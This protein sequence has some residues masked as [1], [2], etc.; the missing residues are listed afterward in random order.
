[1]SRNLVA[2]F[3]FFSEMFFFKDYVFVFPKLFFTLNQPLIL[4]ALC[5][6]ESCIKIKV[7]FNFYFRTSLWCCKWFYVGLQGLYKTFWGTTRSV[8]KN[9]SLFFLCLGSRWEGLR[10]DEQIFY[11]K[12][13]KASKSVTSSQELMLRI[14][15]TF[16]YFF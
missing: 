4:L 15:Y 9:F 7:N 12:K 2:F 10:C 6:S 16:D 5:I 3:F 14:S 13:N 1:M 11:L 8:K